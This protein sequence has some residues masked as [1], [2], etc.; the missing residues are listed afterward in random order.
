MMRRDP[1]V[2]WR[3]A[4]R[5]RHVEFRECLHLAVEPYIRI[6]PEGVCPAQS[7]PDVLH[8][9]AAEPLHRIVQ[10]MIFEM[11]P[12]ADTKLGG[13]PRGHLAFR[14]RPADRAVR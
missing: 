13:V 1:T 3:E 2:L 4:E 14:E 12:L 5:D 11:K 7:C 9:E 6:W 8:P 10:A